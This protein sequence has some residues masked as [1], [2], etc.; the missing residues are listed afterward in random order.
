MQM[1]A[2]WK[3]WKSVATVLCVL[4][5]SMRVH[6]QLDESWSMTV[7][8]QTVP[9]SP[10]GSFFIP[11]IAAPDLF[12]PEGPGSIADF[13]SDDFLRVT[14]TST[15][16]GVTRYVVSEIFQIEEGVVYEV[17][18]LTFT[19]TPPILP[20]DLRASPD[21]ATLTSKG[22]TTQVRV[23]AILG[24]GNTV[25]VSA[26]SDATVY[27]TSNA[28]VATVGQEGL[29]TAVAEGPVFITAVNSGAAAVTRVDV[30][31]GSPLTRVQG[32][33]L[34][35]N[36]E[37]IVG[38]S[39]TLIGQAGTAITQSD[40]SFS[41]EGVDAASDTLALVANFTAARELSGRSRNLPPVAGAIT[42]MGIIRPDVLC[43]DPLGEDC[44]DTDEDGVPDAVERIFGMDPS[45]PDSDGD[46]FFDGEELLKGCNPLLPER[47]TVVGR[48]VDKQGTPIRGAEVQ[49]VDAQDKVLSDEN[50]TFIFPDVTICRT[51]QIM[52]RVIV[53][54]TLLQGNSALI[55][56]LHNSVTDLG[57][58][59]LQGV[60]DSLYPDRKFLV[61]D[62][63][64]SIVTVDLDRDGLIDAAVANAASSD[65]SILLGNG[66]GSFRPEERIPIGGIG[67]ALTFLTSADLNDDEQLDLIVTSS[68]LVPFRGRLR[69]LLGNGDGSFQEAITHSVGVNPSSLVIEDINHD[70]KQDVIIET[71]SYLAVMYGN[72]DGTLQDEVLLQTGLNLAT[73]LVAQL[74]DDTHFDIIGV[75]GSSHSVAV[76]LGNGD[77]SFQTPEEYPT[78]RSPVW[79]GLADVNDDGAFDILTA[80]SFSD[81]ISVLLGNGDGTFQTAESFATGDDPRF[82]TTAHLDEDTNIDL[83]V[84]NA[85]SDTLSVLRGDGEGRFEIVQ[86]YNAGDG[87][88]VI[89]V[90]DLNNDQKSD[91]ITAQSSSDD[92]SVYMGSGDNTL[93]V[94]ERFNVGVRPRSIAVGDV[95]AD[96][97]PDLLAPIQGS[98]VGA[99]IAV[100][101][102]N[103]NGTFQDP[104]LFS[105][106]S[107]P[108]SAAFGDFDQN[109]SRD[110]ATANGFG[111]NISV[112][113]GNNDATFSERQN[114]STGT[115]PAWLI[116]AHLDDDEFQDI[117]T[118]NELSNDVSVLL[119]K[120]DGSFEEQTRF[121]VGLRPS[122]LTMGKLDDNNTFDLVTA[123]TRSGD[124]SILLGDGTG[125]FAEEMRLSAGQLPVH[126]AIDDLNTD[127]QADLIVVDSRSNQVLV[128]LG[129]NDGS[130]QEPQPFSVGQTPAFVSVVD[131]NQDRSLDLV[132]ANER[133]DD[134]DILFGQGD[135]TFS[136]QQRYLVGDNPVGVVIQDVNADGQEDLI[137]VNE[138][139]QDIT[140][141][142]HF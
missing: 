10:D 42:D 31:L 71:S 88:F 49:L 4:G 11:N 55:D 41:I 109:G 66:D 94:Q 45:A 37:P 6:A 140:V 80:N 5:C 139:S 56:A 36:E 119:G 117:A 33:F 116:V 52:A 97:L 138:A 8:G 63:P 76:F 26:R 51:V 81:D 13:L 113:L 87:L 129:N 82:L 30:A 104:M 25:D 120:G 73:V 24:D 67:D 9:V 118:P 89:S 90:A 3:Y 65:L 108:F 92:I 57:D 126:V 125:G 2:I 34:R 99:N 28:E 142:L 68:S 40:G 101:I 22:E 1:Q 17:S 35:W 134:V 69:T 74:N 84:A 77:G 14:G 53:E 86:E 46:G 122:F 15:K 131:I 12:G 50:G 60:N 18:D 114:F 107:T 32:F 93:L 7:N 79:G 47:T 96:V 43:D 123:N 83:L 27:R 135:G 21:S 128:L 121:P 72:G 54:N 124:L 44:E 78:G 132:V 127:D 48:T 19:D 105:A 39:I 91:V 106:E 141:L 20:L 98:F 23:T 61:G 75:N 70:G 115:Q 100:L 85:R 110:I 59:M 130:F 58:V 38:A 112:L 111:N 137:T 102:G 62:R 29:V 103:G 16:N 95:N 136:A 64:V 133:S